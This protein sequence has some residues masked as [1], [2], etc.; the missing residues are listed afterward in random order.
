LV[1]I[2]Q[3]GMLEGNSVLSAGL[4]CGFQPYACNTMHITQFY[5][6]KHNADK[7]KV[8][9]KLPMTWLAFVT[10]YGLRQIRGMF[11]TLHCLHCL[12]CIALCHVRCVGC[13]RL[14]TALYQQQWSPW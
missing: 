2:R 5:E 9:K 7:Y 10:W 1:T 14:E 13:I 8:S 12:C 4:K 11:W 3:Q 6:K